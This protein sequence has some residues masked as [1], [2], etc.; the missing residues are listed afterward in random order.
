MIFTGSVTL[1]LRGFKILQNL[2][3]PKSITAAVYLAMFG[4]RKPEFLKNYNRYHKKVL[5]H[6]KG[7]TKLPPAQI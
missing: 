3:Y 7:D 4:M 5:G 2:D 1:C 6:H